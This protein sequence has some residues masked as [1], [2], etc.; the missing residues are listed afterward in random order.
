MVCKL[1][2]GFRVSGILGLTWLLHAFRD[3]ELEDLE[4]LSSMQGDYQNPQGQAWEWNWQSAQEW[5]LG[6]G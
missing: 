3:L 5:E 6:N 4:L 1:L 2:N